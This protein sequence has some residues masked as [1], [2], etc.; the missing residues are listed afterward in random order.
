MK[1]LILEPLPL[2]MSALHSK[3]SCKIIRT[4]A[5]GTTSESLLWFQF[6][7]DITPPDDDDCDAYL[8]AT[9]MDAMIENRSIEVQGRVSKTLLS[10]LVEYQAAWSK[11]LPD[12]STGSNTLPA[13]PD[14]IG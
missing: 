5:D 1:S 2:A 14:N 12:T 3:R 8:L 9:I 4:E 6:T 11:W 13:N 7:K 10:N